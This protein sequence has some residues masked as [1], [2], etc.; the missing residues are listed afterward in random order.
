MSDRWAEQE[1]LEGSFTGKWCL[2][3]LQKGIPG[4]LVIR[5]LHF[6]CRG[7]RLIPAQG[8][9]IL[10]SQVGQKQKKK[11]SSE[12]FKCLVTIFAFLVIVKRLISDEIMVMY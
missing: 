2:N 3:W 1:S 11:L 8:T 7:P 6:H 5:T 4:G 10:T 9:R 12:R